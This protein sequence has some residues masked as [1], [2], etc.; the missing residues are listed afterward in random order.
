MRNGEC[1]VDHNRQ[2]ATRRGEALQD[3]ASVI[4]FLIT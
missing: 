2:S 1:D 4:G 3:V